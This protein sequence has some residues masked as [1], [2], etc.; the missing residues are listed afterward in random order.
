MSLTS[1]AKATTV[2]KGFDEKN[3][4]KVIAI[5][6]AAGAIAFGVSQVISQPAADAPTATQAQNSPWFYELNTHLPQGSAIES[7]VQRPGTYDRFLDINMVNAPQVSPAHESA[8]SERFLL[9]NTGDYAVADT[10][11][12]E[13]VVRPGA[14]Q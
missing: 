14:P 10:Q 11:T 4:A 1:T 2:R 12:A 7:A 5:I 6:A 13:L 8:A 3:L 9:I